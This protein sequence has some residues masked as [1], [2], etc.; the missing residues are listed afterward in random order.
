V[1]APTADL[2]VGIDELL[3]LTEGAAG[4]AYREFRGILGPEQLALIDDPAQLVS[5]D[6]GRRSGKTTAVI[7]KV[8]QTFEQFQRARCFYFAPTG[9]QGVDILWEHVSRYNHEFDFGWREHWSDKWWTK[10]ERRLE[11]FS[12]H[13]RD[14]V[15]RARGR[16]ANFIDVDEAQLAPD[17]FAK[18][19]E[20]SILPTTADYRGTAGRPGR[21]PR[22][23]TASSSR[24]ATTPTSGRAVT[25]GPRIRTRSFCARAATCWPSS[26]R[27]T[28]GR[29]TT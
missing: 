7:G 18:R 1:A 2:L 3:D 10:G 21:R 26:W 22:W 13:D 9:E 16:W 14:D 20:S 4:G 28:D 24:R 6:P 5:A 15:E 23:Q 27:S 25:T 19:F 12:F 8:A 29:P 17:W 11:V